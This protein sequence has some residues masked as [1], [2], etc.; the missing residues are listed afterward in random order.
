M[1]FRCLLLIISASFGIKFAVA[2]DV[3]AIVVASG[4]PF[5]LRNLHGDA[6]P[7]AKPAVNVMAGGCS[8][9]WRYR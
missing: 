9:E 7:A 5:I 8:S 6:Y 1:P 3:L 2:E 4:P